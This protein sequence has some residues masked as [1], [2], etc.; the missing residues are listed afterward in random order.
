MLNKNPPTNERYINQS[1]SV[2]IIEMA[3]TAIILIIGIHTPLTFIAQQWGISFGVYLLIS[4]ITTLIALAITAWL[5]NKV[6]KQNRVNDLHILGWLSLIGI[7]FAILSLITNHPTTDDY[8]Y[9]PNTVY[10]M[11]HP[12]QPMDFNLHFLYGARGTGIVSPSQA[13]SLAYEY[14][15]AVVA[16]YLKV[17]FAKL[18]FRSGMLTVF[19]LPFA[20]FLSMSRF[21]KNSQHA[22]IGTLG[23]LSVLL[24]S[25]DGPR[26]YA[27]ATF[28]DAHL[29]K[30][31]L[32][33]IGIPIFSAFSISFL[34]H[35]SLR[36]WIFLSFCTMALTGMTSSAILLLP[37]LALT[38]VGTFLVITWLDRESQ[39]IWKRVMI[40][41]IIY[42]TSLSYAFVYALFLSYQ[43]K[44]GLMTGNPFDLSGANGFLDN[45]RHTFNLA[46]PV[47]L[48]ILIL[49]F[50]AVGI[51]ARSKLEQSVLIWSAILLA[52]FL[53]PLAFSILTNTIVPP[54]IYWRMFFL[55]PFPLT[56][57]VA[58][59]ST[60]INQTINKLLY[61]IFPLAVCVYLSVTYQ[62][63]YISL[64]LDDLP[65]S[66]LDLARQIIGVAPKGLMLAPH[67]LSGPITILSSHQ[68]QLIT[69]NTALIYWIS[70][71][72]PDSEVL[73]RTSTEEF[74]MAKNQDI[75][76]FQSLLDAY[77]QIQSIILAKEAMANDDVLILF[78]RHG[79][80]HH[81]EVQ[82]YILVWK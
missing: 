76:S 27:I 64:A 68:P 17:D 40:I 39:P 34:K 55:I 60:P 78:E 18:Y 36:Y 66:N 19:L 38:L 21:A 14:F 20:Y 67:S 62:Q 6:F 51:F 77:P 33:S 48:G 74:I 32:L 70:P 1:L 47:T 5:Y 80:A 23:I 69:L 8:F 15:R 12:N 2:S 50:V 31:I 37:I 58:I 71:Q 29:G 82:D 22:F 28:W 46:H 35:P 63:G 30:L 73:L 7:A 79:F 61:A 3:F 45:L 52:T 42:F 65:V 49:S 24:I 72:S 10:F 57:G 4:P 56:V 59:T 26:T 75:G 81:T 11:Q 43:S 54:S 44:Q 41:C 9:I 16:S 13:T 53:N 25:I